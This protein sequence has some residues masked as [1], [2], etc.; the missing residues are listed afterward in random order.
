MPRRRRRPPITVTLVLPAEPPAQEEIDAILMAADSI[1]GTAGRSGMAFPCSTTRPKDGNGFNGC[2]WSGCW[3]GSR[4]GRGSDSHT[5]SGPGW[6]PS[7]GTS[8]SCS[9]MPPA[10]GTCVTFRPCYGPGFPT[11][12]GRYGPPSTTPCSALASA[13]SRIQAANRDS[14]NQLTRRAAACYPHGCGEDSMIQ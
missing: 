12:Y 14:F 6:R 4:A 9:S 1:V 10:S 2:G 3:A 7:T 8:S 11:R 5:R 13:R